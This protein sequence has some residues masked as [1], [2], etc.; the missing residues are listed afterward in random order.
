M[1]PSD[2]ARQIVD[3]ERELQRAFPQVPLDKVRVQVEQT[4]M[5]YLHAPVRDYVPLLVSREV[6]AW[7]QTAP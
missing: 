7:L 2:E 3:L 1:E 5:K 4:W 6:R